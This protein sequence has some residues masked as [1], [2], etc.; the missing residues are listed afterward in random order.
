MV[1]VMPRRGGAPRGMTVPGGA[2]EAMRAAGGITLGVEEEFVL[3]DPSTGATVLAA[4]DLVRMLDGEPGVQ[5]ELMRFQVEI[6]TRVCT[7]LDGLGRELTGS[8]CSSLTRRRVW[9]AVWWPRGS[10]CSERP[11]W[12]PRRPSPGTRSWPAGTVCWS[13]RPGPAAAMCTSG[14]PPATWASRCWRGCGPGWRRCWPSPSTPRS[15]TAVT[16]VGQL[17]APGLVPLA[18][19]DGAVGVAGRGRLRRDGPRA[20]RPG[21]GAGRSEHLRPRAAVPA[22]P[23]GRGPGRRRLPRR[24]HRSAGVRADPRPGRDRPG[25]GPAG[26]PGASVLDAGHH[27]DRTQDAQ[28]GT[29]APWKSLSMASAPAVRTGRRSR[30]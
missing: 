8:G 22:L 2:S 15:R 9:A 4:S 3:L 21:R 30:R 27:R 12:P 7:S 18:H 20:H 23:D 25:R 11:G 13:P 5:Q 24:R 19:G 26:D 6:A 28:P 17:A 1:V 14:F 10:R 29:G 16:G